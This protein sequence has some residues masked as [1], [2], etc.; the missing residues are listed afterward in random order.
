MVFDG[1]ILIDAVT[2]ILREGQNQFTLDNY[3]SIPDN[4]NFAINLYAALDHYGGSFVDSGLTDL[5]GALNV[6]MNADHC[7][8]GYSTCTP[9]IDVEN[10]KYSFPHHGNALGPMNQATLNM[11]K[12]LLG[13]NYLHTFY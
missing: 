5:E 10:P 9:Q 11:I 4:V 6:G 8:I 3:E 1:L 2:T 7:S 12:Y 13:H